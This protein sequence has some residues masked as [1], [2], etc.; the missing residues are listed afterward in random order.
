[1][2]DYDPLHYWL[3]IRKERWPDGTL[4]ASI[5]ERGPRALLNE[6]MLALAA[7]DRDELASLGSLADEAPVVT[8]RVCTTGS[9]DR[10]EPDAVL[11]R[12]DRRPDVR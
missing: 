3:L 1:M 2:S 8:Y 6:R 12:L 10:R 11:R 4:D 5:I 7:A 9:W